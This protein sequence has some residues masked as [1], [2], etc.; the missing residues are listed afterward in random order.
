MST[1]EYTKDEVAKHRTA[2]DFWTVVDGV[3]YQLDEEFVRSIHPGGLYIMEA[4]GKDGS[5]LFHE[6][7]NPE[8]VMP[9]LEEY[10]I[11]VIQQ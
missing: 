5:T 10:R 7:H 9:A 11:G 1:M 4:A 3:V 8:A 6:N 2:T